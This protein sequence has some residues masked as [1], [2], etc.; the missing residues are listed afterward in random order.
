MVELLVSLATVLVLGAGMAQFF[1]TETHT[2][3]QQEQSV[4][5]E[6]NL[7]LASEML[8]DAMRNARYGSPANT[9]LSSWV[10]W[11]PGFPNAN[12]AITYSSGTT[13]SS[14]S[15]A[16]CFEEPVAE[17]SAPANPGDVTLSASPIGA[18]ALSDVL[19]IAPNAKSLIRIGE[20]GDYAQ[21]TGLGGSTI[22]VDTAITSGVQP[23]TK[24]YPANT[25]ICRVDV[26]TFTLG[27]DPSTGVPRLLRNDNTGGGAQSAAEGIES[28]QISFSPPNRYTITLHGRS[29]TKEPLRGDYVRRD[30]STT[31]ALRP[32]VAGS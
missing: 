24:T 14:L 31:V 16:A 13:V 26:L 7:R 25:K 19:D 12:P 15:L 30:L 8:T 20:S 2:H 10:S 28:L 6:Q 5:L 17:L 23:L 22:G 1:L 18:A 4:S 27:N 3:A 32:N 9:Q 21:I 29:E 11:I